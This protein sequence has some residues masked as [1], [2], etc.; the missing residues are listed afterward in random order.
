MENQHIKDIVLLADSWAWNWYTNHQHDKKVDEF[1]LSKTHNDL[2]KQINLTPSSFPIVECLLCSY[3]YNV[4][5]LANPGCCNRYQVEQ[6][7]NYLNN[8]PDNIDAIL[9]VQTDPVRDIFECM[10]SNNGGTTIDGWEEDLVE[11]SDFGQWTPEYLEKLM[12]HTMLVIYKRLF[13][14]LAKH[15]LH[16]P[17]FMMGGCGTVQP[18]LVDQAVAETGYKNAHVVC[19]S[20]ISTGYWLLSGNPGV[21]PHPSAL[22]RVSCYANSSWNPDLISFLYDTGINQY[23]EYPDVDRILWPDPQH[24][25]ATTWIAMIEHLNQFIEDLN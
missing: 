12:D 22:N 1:F 6:L 20:V 11:Q 18:Y 7:E 8:N 10:L 5:N 9:F 24:A 19:P 23:R 16:V 25:N 13:G 21:I 3:G 17:V 14:V 4:K 15:D 2:V